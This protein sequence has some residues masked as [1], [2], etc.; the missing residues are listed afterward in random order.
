MRTKNIPVMRM[1]GFAAEAALYKKSAYRILRSDVQ[2]HGVEPAFLR[3]RGNFCCDE[4]G[5]CIYKGPRLM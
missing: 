4:W 2:A 3:C 1:P 5:N